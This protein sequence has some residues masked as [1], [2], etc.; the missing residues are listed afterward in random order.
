[1]RGPD[2]PAA[3]AVH[4]AYDAGVAT[5]TLNR[6]ESLNAA[7][8]ALMR[9]LERRLRI[10][11]KLPGLRV[12]ILTGAGGAFSA[13]GNLIEFEAALNA[14][15]TKLVDTLRYN[16][17]VLQMIED[18][19]VP[20]IAA[21]NGV[22]VAGGLETLLCCDIIVAA[23]DAKIGDGHT[24]Y[25]VVPAGGATVRLPERIGRS[26]AAQLFYTA[27]LA[28][29]VTLKDW[30]LVN[31]VV[32]RDKLMDRTMELAREICRRSPEAI[33]HIKA[34]TARGV[35]PEARGNCI[36]AELERFDEHVN[37][38]DLAKGLAAFR[39]KEAPQF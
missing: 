21:V 34:L 39:A 22:A 14:G 17:D 7:S 32:P 5:L 38:A 23:E 13:G 1:V 33:R 26:R 31:E 36:R 4:L 15:G 35:D 19:P 9:S 27:A 11:A 37:G 24:R 18:L 30:G 20:V 25:G 28:D 12:V 2:S 6:A 16:Q 10:V 8:E 29:A 3:E